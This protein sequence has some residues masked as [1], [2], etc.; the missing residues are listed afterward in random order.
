MKYKIQTSAFKAT[1]TLF[2]VSICLL[3]LSTLNACLRLDSNLYNPEKSSE[4]LLDEYAGNKEIDLD[5]KY[6]IDES[7]VTLFT[8]ES[9]AADED[10]ATTIWAMYV[11]DTSRIST[12]T[13][14]MY[15]HGNARNMDAYYPRVKLLANAGHKHRYGVMQFDYRGYG[16]SEGWETEEGMYTDLNTCL[17]WLKEHGLTDDRLIIYGFSLGS[18]C[19]TELTANPRALQPS[20]LMLEA[21]FASSDVMA[22]DAGVLAM[23]ASFFTD[24]KIDNAEEIKKVEEPFL[25]IHGMEDSFLNIE[26]HGE[27]V[28]KNY[29]GSY[30]K[31]I[32]VPLAIH[33][34]VPEIYGYE[35]YLHDVLEFIER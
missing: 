3:I 27:V 9:Q 33:S 8:L 13:I 7:N 15:C 29:Q 25:W 31:A 35:T 20:K 2:K 26:T 14:I 12:D 34:N 23:P 30:S 28:Y 24:V 21:P 4:Y 16:M 22:Q 5:P 6:D 11:G 17:L 10:T 1:A 32:R 18:S 19:A